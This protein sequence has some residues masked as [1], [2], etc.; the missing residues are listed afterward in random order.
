[1]LCESLLDECIVRRPRL[2][3]DAWFTC[4]A[5]HARRVAG[6]GGGV[7][8]VRGVLTCDRR[9]IYEERPGTKLVQREDAMPGKVEMHAGGEVSQAMPVSL[10]GDDMRT[11]V[12]RFRTRTR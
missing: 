1:M 11:C 7:S 5:R 4:S 12:S 9:C 3:Y 6:R 8:I 10:Y 2:T